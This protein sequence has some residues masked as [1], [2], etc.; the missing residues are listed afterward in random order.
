MGLRG[1][2]TPRA[3]RGFTLIELLVVVAIIALL[4]AILLPSLNQARAQARTTVCLSRVAQMCKA[5]LMY[6]EDYDGTPPFISTMHFHGSGPDTEVP[7]PNET[8][9]MNCLPAA[10]PI[11]A[12]RSIA[13]GSED[14]WEV[15]V[16]ESGTLHTYAKFEGIYRCPDFERVADPLKTHNAFNYTR[17]IWGRRYRPYMEMYFDYGEEDCSPWGDVSGPILRIDQVYAPAGLPLVLDEQ[18]DRHVAISGAYGPGP[19]GAPY[20]CNDYGFYLE[21]N[22]AVS[23][24]IPVKSVLHEMDTETHWGAYEHFLWKRGG[25]AFYDGHAALMRDPWPAFELGNN[26]RLSSGFDYAFRTA[27]IAGRYLDEYH[28]L[29]DFIY[30]LCFWQRGFDPYKKWQH[31]FE[32]PF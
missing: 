7:D 32:P 17:P 21:N 23:H 11:E 27:S 8:W 13:Y 20:C 14:E 30:Y 2:V 25:V 16:P 24:G 22:I 28:A 4:I 12:M 29:E 9:L 26:R 3:R 10:D 19:V 18:W 5:F 6:A 1:P 31:L 15:P